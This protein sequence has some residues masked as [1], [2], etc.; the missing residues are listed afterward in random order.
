M[1]RLI[2]CVL[3]TVI[4]F[5]TAQGAVPDQAQ[6]QMNGYS[7]VSVWG[8]SYVQ[9]FTCGITGQL[10]HVDLWVVGWENSGPPSYPTTVAI[11]CVEDGVPIWSTLGQVDSCIFEAGWNSVDFSSQSVHLTAGTQYGIMLYNDDTTVHDHPTVNL[12]MKVGP[13]ADAY[14]GGSLWK[15]NPGNWQDDWSP[16][17]APIDGCFRTYMIAQATMSLA[18]DIKP[19]SCPNPLNVK[20]N[21]LLPVAVLGTEELDVTTIDVA[22]VRLAGVAAVRSGFEDVAGPVPDDGPCACSTEG[23]DGYTDLTLKFKTWE[24]AE[25]IGPVTKGDTLGLTLTGTLTDGTPAEGSDCIVIVGNIPRGLAARKADVTG[26]GL[27]DMLDFG[28]VAEHWL[29]FCVIGY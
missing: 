17:I 26:D 22:S 9:T 8:S 3:A 2:V 13:G 14:D 4:G 10:D 1:K 19:G 11:V 25:A 18:V 28:T 5:G 23:A 12:C 16:Q 6:E 20:S 27:V 15:G 21:G 7:S 29:E 24:I